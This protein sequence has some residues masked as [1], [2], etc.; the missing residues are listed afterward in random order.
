[1]TSCKKSYGCNCNVD[2][3]GSSLSVDTTYYMGIMDKNEA[4]A[5]CT[6]IKTDLQLIMDQNPDSQGT[7]VSCFKMEQ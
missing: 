7:T 4:T 6:N 3:P 2:I 5:R 1:M